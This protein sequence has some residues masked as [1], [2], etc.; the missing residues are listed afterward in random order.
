MADSG[1]QAVESELFHV[2]RLRNHNGIRKVEC[3]KCGQP[4][5]DLRHA[6]C[7]NCRTAYMKKWRSEHVYVKRVP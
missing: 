1:E 2:K 5:S 4:K 6:Y 3:S 7:R